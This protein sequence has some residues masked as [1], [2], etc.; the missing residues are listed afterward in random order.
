MNPNGK[1]AR[2]L[3]VANPGSFPSRCRQKRWEFFRDLASSV[4]R[5]MRILDVGG[6]Q[7]VW[8]R[9][10]FTNQPGIHITILNIEQHTSKYANVE[11]DLG[12]ACGMPQYRDKEFDIVFSN[13]V[14][15]HVGNDVRIRQMA[16]ELRRVGRN[17][18][19]QTP[20]YY[21]PV[22]P[23]FFFPF[24]QFLPISVRTTLGQHLNLFFINKRPVRA[25]AEA[26]VR[27]INL[28]TKRQVKELFPLARIV[29]ERLFGIV[30]SIQAYEFEATHRA[31]GLYLYRC[32]PDP[33]S[34][35]KEIML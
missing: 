8:E 24:F 5:P 26:V 7:S 14:I 6:S 20:N 11:C 16:A 3:D 18:Y 35:H 9:I 4:E 28:L 23:H 15:E 25:E 32:S 31:T 12:D 13:S 21:F 30:K 17:Y 34:S 19:I 22:E 2:F 1:L 33:K 27:N 29:E 10:G